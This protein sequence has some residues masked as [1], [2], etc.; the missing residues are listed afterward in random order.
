MSDRVHLATADDV[1]RLVAPVALAFATDAVVRYLLPDSTDFWTMF[2]KAVRVHAET[3][4]GY[5]GCY[6]T[7][8]DRGAAFWYPPDRH[9]DGEAI[10][11]VWS[12]ALDT[13]RLEVLGQAFQEMS[14]Y[15]PEEPHMYLRMI[16][17]DPSLQGRGYGSA[18]IRAALEDTDRQGLRAY[19]EAS[20]EASRALYE[21]HGFEV[22]GEVQVGDA[23]PFWPMLRAQVG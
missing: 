15:E 13:R 4:T 16:G 2:P 9:V 7:E 23:P 5:G 19:L 17:V 18:L 14:A 3:T 12:G 11:A 1:E 20:S 21:R 6:R 8:D 10:G 22:V